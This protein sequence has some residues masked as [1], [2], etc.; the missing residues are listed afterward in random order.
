MFSCLQVEE[1]GVEWRE[2][3]FLRTLG[4]R[5]QA[6]ARRRAMRAASAA[7]DAPLTTALGYAAER[8]NSTTVTSSN[9]LPLAAAAQSSVWGKGGLFGWGD[10]PW[11]VVRVALLDGAIAVAQSSSDP[12]RTAAAAA[13][14]VGAASGSGKGVAEVADRTVLRTRDANVGPSGWRFHRVPRR[15]CLGSGLWPLLLD[16]STVQSAPLLLLRM[17]VLDG[18]SPH[19]LQGGSSSS[20]FG[21]PSWVADIYTKLRWCDADRKGGIFK[22]KSASVAMSADDCYGRGIEGAW[23]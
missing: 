18:L 20:P 10:G 9:S 2:T 19:Y 7:A 22:P 6:L 15:A 14:T 23:K 4:H 11:D 5:R 21:A 12:E 8:A 13:A 1:L 3:N 17:P 16:G